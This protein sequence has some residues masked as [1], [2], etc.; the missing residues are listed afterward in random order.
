MAPSYFDEA[1][2]S[3]HLVP[4]LDDNY[5]F[6]IEGASAL[7]AFDPG[8]SEPLLHFAKRLQKPLIALFLTHHHNDHVGGVSKVVSAYDGKIAV[9]GPEGVHPEITRTAKDGE[10]FRL[11][12]EEGSPNLKAVHTPAHTLS[13]Y[14][15]YSP[16]L[17]S[18]FVG[19]ILFPMGCGFD[20]EGDASNLF[21]QLKKY[22]LLPKDTW[23]Y[24]A[25]EYG[26]KNAVFTMGLDGENPKVQT[27]F[28]L[29]LE[30]RRRGLP[31]VPTTLIEELHTNLFYHPHI[32]HIAKRLGVQN[33]DPLRCFEA[34]LAAKKQFQYHPPEL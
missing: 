3:I 17:Q 6:V 18:L 23:I 12:A 25:H 15:Y 11:F 20:F 16:E 19:D 1:P 21:A 7:V 29:F 24:S 2:S 8:D 32:I 10:V 13:H 33:L 28:K 30:R 34:L 26:L 4:M 9:I 5:C 22:A 31:T 14:S 27:R